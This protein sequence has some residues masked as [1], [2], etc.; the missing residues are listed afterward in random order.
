MACGLPV[1]ATRIAGN[2]DL[3][4]NGENGFLVSNENVIELRDALR[5]LLTDKPLRLKMGECSRAIVENKFSWSHSGEEY[6][7][8]LQKTVER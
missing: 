6:L 2:E 4:K 3:V 8:L 5:T 1:I 7:A